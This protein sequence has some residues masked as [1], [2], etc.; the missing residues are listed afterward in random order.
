M[1]NF[2]HFYF[3]P[4]SGPW[5]TGA[6]WGNMVAWVI[7]GALAFIWGRRKFVKW[8]RR[9]KEENERAHQELKEHIT[10]GHEDIKRHITKTHRNK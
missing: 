1:L 7:C 5:Y 10:K 6:V 2:Y 4:T 3:V 9:R 8:D